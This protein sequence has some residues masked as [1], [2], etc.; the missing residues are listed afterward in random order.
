MNL[1]ELGFCDWFKDK[2]DPTK[3]TEYKIA[4][5]IAVNKGSYIIKNG[6]NDVLAEITGKLMF[7]A[8]SPLP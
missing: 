4:R 3:I 1:Y 8:D 7:S 5:V 2:V 6:K